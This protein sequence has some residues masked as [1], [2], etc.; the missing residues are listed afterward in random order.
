MKIVFNRQKII[1]AA[2]PLLC[3]VSNKTTQMSIEGIL[4]EAKEP[5]ECI[6]TTYDTEKGVRIPVET[7]VYEGGSY[8]INAQKF[9]SIIKVMPENEVT[10]TVSENRQATF[11]CGTS[12]HKTV[13]LPGADFP[14][15]PKLRSNFGFTVSQHVMKNMMSKCQHAMAVADLRPILNGCYFDI[16]SERM[17][18]VSC[19][20]FR[21][22]M[23]SLI[24]DIENNNVNNS[25]VNFRFVLPIRTVNEVY[26][27]L[28]GDKEKDL[29]MRIYMS[30]HEIVFIIGQIT[31]FSALIEGQ[32]IDYNRIVKIP[33][34]GT[35]EVDRLQFVE[36]LIRARLITEEAIDGHTRPPI[37]LTVEG[38]SLDVSA[39]N[40]NGSYNDVLPIS[41]DGDDLMISFNNKFLIDALS[42]SEAER[43]KVSF[44]STLSGI[45][46][47][48]AEGEK[49]LEKST[50][51]FMIL[52][53]RNK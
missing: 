9:F 1:T 27:L 7:T 13:V 10:L 47:E 41:H 26:K 3:A 12:V 4:I 20:S 5:N 2:A 11:T 51:L 18:A 46:V 23:C 50:E 33:V 45:T 42:A 8:I 21:V 29:K 15:L 34:K 25:D 14:A 44:S 16:N 24:T 28:D 40:I 6:M 30:R 19:D 17:L 43:V 32:Y 52:P 31:F 37:K 36:T 53:V 35:F 49:F 39:V 48:P 38:G 22:A